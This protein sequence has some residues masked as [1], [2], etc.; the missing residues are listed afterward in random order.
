MGSE[1]CKERLK[2][3]ENGLYLPS[4]PPHDEIIDLTLP[5]LAPPE[6]QLVLI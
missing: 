2:Q 1:R 4:P 5:S 3:E 6:Y